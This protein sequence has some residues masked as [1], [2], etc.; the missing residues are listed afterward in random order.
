MQAERIAAIESDP[1]LELERIIYERDL[2]RTRWLIKAYYRTRIRK[3]EQ[4]VQYYLHHQE[5]TNRLSQAEVEY[6][7]EYF[8]CIGR[9]VVLC[10]QWVIPCL[11]RS[12]DAIL[13]TSLLRHVFLCGD[14]AYQ[15]RCSACIK[16]L[17]VKLKPDMIGRRSS[18]SVAIL[19]SIACRHAHQVILK[20]LPQHY[21]SFTFSSAAAQEEDMISTPHTKRTVLMRPAFETA[22]IATA[23]NE[24]ALPPD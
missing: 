19:P 12:G 18:T 4:H 15:M 20:H 7:K 8:T 10:L 22:S 17:H 2:Q 1:D 16:A 23:E 21:Q 11:Y 13:Q 3:L 14:A 6:A 5:Y 24:C 9:C